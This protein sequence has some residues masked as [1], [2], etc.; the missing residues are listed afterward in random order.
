MIE[1]NKMKNLKKKLE[2]IEDDRIK[3]KKDYTLEEVE[4]ILEKVI[5]KEECIT[6]SNCYI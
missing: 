5:E 4:E 3:G 1:K 6:V 2:K